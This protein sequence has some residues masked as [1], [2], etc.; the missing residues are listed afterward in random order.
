MYFFSVI[1]DYMCDTIKYV[2]TEEGWDKNFEDVSTQCNKI[3]FN[4]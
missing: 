3:Y 4:N 2:V 1:D